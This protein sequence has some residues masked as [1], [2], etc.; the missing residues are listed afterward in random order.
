MMFLSKILTNAESRYWSTKL[1]MIE[2]V[3]IIK[4]IRHL[5]EFSRKQFTIIFTNHSILTKIIKQT[6][7]TFS[8]MNKLNLRLMK[9]SQYLLILS[10]DIK[11]KLEKFHIILDVLFRLFFVMN[12]D[13]STIDEKDVLKN[14]QY[15]I[16]AMFVHFLSEYRT[17]SFDVKS[18]YVSEYLNVHFE[19]KEIRLGMIRFDSVFVIWESNRCRFDFLSNRF[20]IDLIRFDFLSIR[21]RW[22]SEVKNSAY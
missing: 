10:I 21:N 20:R 16:D 17:S 9:T 1:K 22:K 12:S 13:K 2:V 11:I 4:K 19:Q 15:D 14:L 8:N 7:F 18:A 6:F 3:W 5:I